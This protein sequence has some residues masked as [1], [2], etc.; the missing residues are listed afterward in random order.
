[1]N[2]IFFVTVAVVAV[3]VLV[4]VD[5]ALASPGGKI[6]KA[7]Y[8]TFWGRIV[9]VILTIIFLPLIIYYL[10]NHAIAEWRA[11]KDLRFMAK[12]SSK[13]DW[14]TIRSRVKD[15]FLRVHA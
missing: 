10:A 12:Y 8:E 9:L 7:A 6:A 13:F 15:C 1:M 2:R 14:L 3:T 5:P 11:R 4:F